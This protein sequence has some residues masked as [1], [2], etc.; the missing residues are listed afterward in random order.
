MFKI[1]FKCNFKSFYS[2]DGEP[3]LEIIAGVKSKLAFTAGQRQLLNVT[4]DYNNPR[5]L[6]PYYIC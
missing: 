1:L 6:S 2:E 4:C 5:N 3:N